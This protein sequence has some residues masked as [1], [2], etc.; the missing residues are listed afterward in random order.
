MAGGWSVCTGR[1]VASTVIC[2]PVAALVALPSRW[3]RLAKDVVAAATQGPIILAGDFHARTR[4][5]SD[6][7]DSNDT[8][9][10]Q[11]SEDRGAVSHHG[12]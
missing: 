1:N 7:P 4:T 5:E 8:F 10:P 6:W 2:H 9:K 12:L 3:L 11:I